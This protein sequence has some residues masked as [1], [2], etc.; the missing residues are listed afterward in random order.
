[1]I[2]DQV[3][4]DRGDDSADQDNESNGNKQ[5]TR[6]YGTESFMEFAVNLSW[7]HICIL[8]ER[9][10]HQVFLHLF[11]HRKKVFQTIIVSCRGK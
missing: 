4:A 5:D 2:G 7:L 10:I 9:I 1:M 8:S 11:Y 3:V 6:A